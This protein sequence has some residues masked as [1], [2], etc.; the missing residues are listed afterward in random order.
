MLLVA[1]SRK[2]NM[3]T[4]LEHHLGP[5]PWSLANDTD[6]AALARKLESNVPPAE[7][8]PSPPVCIIDRKDLTT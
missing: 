8:I 2:L 4:V 7:Q 5:T 6:N 3:K 1:S